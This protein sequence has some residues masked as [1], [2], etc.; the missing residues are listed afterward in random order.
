MLDDGFLFLGYDGA[1]LTT[2]GTRRPWV[3]WSLTR[4]SGH[5]LEAG[6]GTIPMG[7][8][9]MLAL[10]VVADVADGTAHIGDELDFAWSCPNGREVG[11]VQTLRKQFLLPKR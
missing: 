9:V 8:A 4:D 5:A 1:R 7:M 6:C 11:Y 2:V 10:A 3:S